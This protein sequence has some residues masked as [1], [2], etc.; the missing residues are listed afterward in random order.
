LTPPITFIRVA[1]TT[2]VLT[3]IE[4]GTWKRKINIGVIREAP[5]T[6][7]KPTT[8]PTKKL[9]NGSSK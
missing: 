6:P 2:S 7:V 1:A 5:P 3:A 9:K 4:G 8:I